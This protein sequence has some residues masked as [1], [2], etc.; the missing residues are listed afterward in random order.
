MSL[1][2]SVRT[3]PP[4][5]TCFGLDLITVEE[6]LTRW[7][8]E[9]ESTEFVSGVQHAAVSTGLTGSADGLFLGIDMLQENKHTYC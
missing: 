8:F 4:E 5:T 7:V 2:S 9:D 3:E 1:S 6:N